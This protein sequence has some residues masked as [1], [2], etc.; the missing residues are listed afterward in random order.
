MRCSKCGANNRETAKFCDS[1]GSVLPRSSPETD[2]HTPE[3]AISFLPSTESA[4]PDSIEGER[5]TVTALFADLKGSTELIRDLDPE[6]AR[7]LVDPAL[8]T[9]VDARKAL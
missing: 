6:E 4:T 7:A 8:R 1:C 9:M 5:K 3:N 2:A